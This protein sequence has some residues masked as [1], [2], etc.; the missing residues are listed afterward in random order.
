MAKQ[1]FTRSDSQQS[2]T[3][4]NYPGNSWINREEPFYD[5]HEWGDNN[6]DPDSIDVLAGDGDTMDVDMAAAGGQARLPGSGNT[7]HARIPAAQP[8]RRK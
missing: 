5:V 1:R 2:D 8:W 4:R 7:A 3:S 6:Q